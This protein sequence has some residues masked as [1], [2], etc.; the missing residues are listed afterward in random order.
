[1]SV[2]MTMSW[3]I[4]P[5]AEARSWTGDEFIDASELFRTFR[6]FLSR[7][8]GEFALRFD[9]VELSFDLDPDLS[10][11]FEDLPDVLE[12]L[13]ED[14]REPVE[15]DFFEQG[16]DI[17]L[18]LARD[19]SLI[20]VRM[21]KGPAAGEGFELPDNVLFVVADEFLE[22]WSLFLQDVLERLAAFDPSVKTTEDYRSYWT[23]IVGLRR[24][25]AG[26]LRPK[27]QFAEVGCDVSA[28][29]DWKDES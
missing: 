8:Q 25:I 7:H 2:P 23:R 16:T 6:R 10:T 20:A 1:M 29:K 5:R 11:V 3:S 13:T 18:N 28:W 15:L 17:A 27:R 14:T 26:R 21:E 19:G 22:T 12:S 9:S 4:L 24:S